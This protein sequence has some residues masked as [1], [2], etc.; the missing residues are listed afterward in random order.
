M[1]ITIIIWYRRITDAAMEVMICMYNTHV[2]VVY[3]LYKYTGQL[4]Q[5]GTVVKQET[6]AK[7]AATK[8]TKA[9]HSAPD[10]AQRR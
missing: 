3:V 7:V 5:A 6:A 2:I 4:H 1:Q 10:K 8:A 9:V